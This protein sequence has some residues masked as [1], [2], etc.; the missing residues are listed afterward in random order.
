M[1]RV[2][3]GPVHLRQ[4]DTQYHG[5]FA[6]ALPRNLT[7]YLG[8]KADLE[9]GEITLAIERLTKPDATGYSG[10]DDERS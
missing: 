5:I 4:T 6:V 7:G 1:K 8:I 9:T 3:T 2:L 10:P